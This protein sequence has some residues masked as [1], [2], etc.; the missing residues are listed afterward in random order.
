MENLEIMKNY[1][2][3]VTEMEKYIYIWKNSLATINNSVQN[4]SNQIYH[5]REELILKNA[6]YSVIETDAMETKK[7][8]Q[9]TTSCLVAILPFVLIFIILSYAAPFIFS[10]ESSEQNMN[11]SE[12]TFNPLIIIIVLAA[13]L[14]IAVI[15]ITAIVV[16]KSIMQKNTKKHWQEEISN[17]KAI[18]IQEQNTLSYNINLNEKKIAELNNRKIIINNNLEKA[19]QELLALYNMNLI[20]MKYRNFVAVSTM[21]DYLENRRCTVIDGYGGIF[22]TYEN[23]V[24]L[25]LIITN[26]IDINKKLNIVI[27]NQQML[28]T[29]MK[30]AN[31]HL[32]NISADVRKIEA[33]TS[34]IE[35]S[36]A[37][38][39]AANQQTAAVARSVDWRLWA[40]GVI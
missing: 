18:S 40:N 30:N 36:A 34:Q 23:D 26:L 20:P 24:K 7:K 39:A 12:S 11:F 3:N 6:Q 38:S 8:N 1:L 29:E 35:K 37:I 33:H 25:G 2:K 28:Y 17:R 19:K 16:I 27:E 4:L 32:S 21:Y 15:S 14:W 10:S 22:A 31:Y 5:F 13:L 9:K